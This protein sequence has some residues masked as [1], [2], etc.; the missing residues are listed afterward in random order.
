MRERTGLAIAF[1]TDPPVLLLDEPL[2][3]LDYEIKLKTIQLMREAAKKSKKIVVV[4]VHEDSDLESSIDKKFYIKK[5][6]IE[7]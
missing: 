6:R 2:E 4:A 7:G 3:N 1:L 5:G